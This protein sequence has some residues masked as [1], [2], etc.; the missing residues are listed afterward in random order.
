[1]GRNIAIVT[2]EDF[3]REV[4]LEDVISMGG[5]AKRFLGFSDLL[6]K[7]GISERED[8]IRQYTYNEFLEENHNKI[9][10]I[11][12][13][14]YVSRDSSLERGLLSQLQTQEY[15][16]IVNLS[17]E[18]LIQNE[19]R[20]KHLREADLSKYKD[21]SLKVLS[22]NKVLTQY[23]LGEA[24]PALIP[25]HGFG[26]FTS[27]D[28]AN[29]E[30]PNEEII[31]KPAQGSLGNGV[32]KINGKDVNLHHIPDSPF[33]VQ[34]A[35]KYIKQKSVEEY[36]R[37]TDLRVIVTKVNGNYHYHGMIR[38]GPETGDCSNLSAGGIGIGI[39]PGRRIE[40]PVEREMARFYDINPDDPRLPR[41]ILEYSKEFADKFN[42]GVLGLDFVAEKTK[43]KPS[44][45]LLEANSNPGEKIFH[46]LGLTNN[47]KLEDLVRDHRLDARIPKDTC[48]SNAQVAKAR[49]LKL[50]H[51]L[52]T[53]GIE[54]REVEEKLAL[55]GELYGFRYK[56]FSEPEISSGSEMDLQQIL[57]VPGNKETNILRDYLIVNG[58][59][60]EALQLR[61][62]RK[63]ITKRIYRNNNLLS[64]ISE[65]DKSIE[66]GI[67]DS[68]ATLKNQYERIT[69]KRIRSKERLNG[70]LISQIKSHLF[71][72]AEEDY[73]KLIKT[74][75]IFN[76]AYHSRDLK[77]KE[78]LYRKVLKIDSNDNQARINLGFVQYKSGKYVAARKKLEHIVGSAPKFKRAKR[79]LKEMDRESKEY[80]E[81]AY[82]SKD[83]STKIKLYETAARLNPHNSKARHNVGF[84]YAKQ[85]RLE[86]GRKVLK[87]LLE[88][89]PGL[90][91]TQRV[92]SKL[93]NGRI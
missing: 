11:V 42:Y 73:K 28:S 49:I 30:L 84:L 35:Q 21:L 75:E 54:M 70:T 60:N 34:L 17:G 36:N 56:G 4:T 48:L 88:E 52:K 32:K 82:L 77:E 92:Y 93:L 43:G 2:K 61:R 58:V 40:D 19:L 5:Q 63:A 68:F 38:V 89:K 26:Y 27:E 78:R 50:I 20:K 22:G 90:K 87:K 15:E 1:M 76:E 86:E 24:H 44:F 80:C 29:L 45:K 12:I 3:P 85:G 14:N 67:V 47:A 55:S 23:L 33:G 6:N 46:Y 41:K 9:D 39:V 64:K 51:T 72:E 7:L 81:Q 69:G 53:A 57:E 66:Q 74:E 25:L 83:L 8:R 59:Q 13:D 79:I 71:K 10:N 37:P 65:V 16:K 91:G 18:S 62:D 31:V